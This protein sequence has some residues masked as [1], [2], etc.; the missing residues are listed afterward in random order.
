M[1]HLI[2]QRRA[3]EK[4]NSKI[5]KE[6]V[7]T[8]TE[9]GGKYTLTGNWV[10]A[11]NYMTVEC[12][13]AFWLDFDVVKKD[14]DQFHKEI[15]KIKASLPIILFHKEVI[16]PD[17]L[18]RIKSMLFSVIS[19][20]N[21]PQK[22]APVMESLNNYIQFSNT[23]PSDINKEFRPNGFGP[24]I[25]NSSPMLN[26]Y[27]MIV[28]VASTD[29]NVLITGETGTG[30]ELVART[31]HNLSDRKNERFISINCGAIP[32]PLLESE[33]F[34]Y[35]K[36][37]FTDATQTKLGKFELGD[38]GT[39]FLDEIG[40]MP[41]NLQ[42]KLLRVLE[43]HKI[44]RLGGTE[45]KQVDIRLLAATNQD[46]GS[47]IEQKKFRSELHYRLNVIPIEISSLDKRG[48]DLVLL[49][50]HIIGKLMTENPNLVESINW[51][52]IEGIKSVRFPGNVREL[53]NV[54]TQIIFQS[55]Q[56]ELVDKILQNIHN[57]HAKIEQEEVEMNNGILPLWK[58]EKE[59]IIR[60][61][62]NLNG[63]ISRASKMLEISRASL[64]RKI[65]K[66][67]LE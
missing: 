40:D 54:L 3:A 48:D 38:K 24:F 33:L 18:F 25:G 20:K 13:D 22:I 27:Q 11:I 31:I 57:D 61:L 55:D 56:P 51:E 16:I 2:C 58:I 12:Y 30:K 39:I 17:L 14:F 46:I 36:G 10:S 47:L 64:Y 67:N 45:E 60:A 42:I 37:A 5:I 41:L 62:Q 21:L 44:E 28:K 52:L 63:N 29:L 1:N 8:I 53:E 66:Y 15:Q 50:L 34:G 7:D 43:D 9:S 32:E 4:T 23:L 65:K 19:K 59:T 35:E 49:T 6:L 26:L